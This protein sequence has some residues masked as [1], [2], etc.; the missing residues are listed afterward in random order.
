MDGDKKGLVRKP[1][2]CRAWKVPSTGSLRQA[3]GKQGLELSRC[4]SVPAR[5]QATALAGRPAEGPGRTTLL[6]S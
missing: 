3:Q 1:F 4:L 6:S 5:A 2:F